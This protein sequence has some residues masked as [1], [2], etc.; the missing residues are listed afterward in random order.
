MKRE[1]GFD[2]M[3][4]RKGALMEDQTEV[5]MPMDKTT[6]SNWYIRNNAYILSKDSRDGKSM[7]GN[8]ENLLYLETAN[9]LSES[10]TAKVVC[11][12]LAALDLDS[13]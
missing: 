6:R 11:L 5:K 13:L 3:N 8:S 1:Q 10:S 7:V 12:W 9:E 2:R 4:K